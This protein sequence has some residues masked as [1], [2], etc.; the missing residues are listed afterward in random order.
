MEYYDL[1]Y[2]L[3]KA[4]IQILNSNIIKDLYVSLHTSTEIG[5]VAL[6]LFAALTFFSFI[7][8]I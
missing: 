5:L 6:N 3:N 2:M 1:F 8:F 4:T 7:V